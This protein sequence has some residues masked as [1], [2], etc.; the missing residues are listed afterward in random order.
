MF[1]EVIYKTAGKFL[2]VHILNKIFI[3]ELERT[4]NLT[5]I[6]NFKFVAIAF[7]RSKLSKRGNK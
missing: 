4:S 3:G 7:K 6:H 2:R 1:P 5:I